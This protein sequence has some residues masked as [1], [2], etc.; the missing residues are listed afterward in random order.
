MKPNRKEQT[1]NSTTRVIWTEAGGR[2]L[3]ILMGE[4]LTFTYNY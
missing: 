4:M 3:R 1:L 2:K